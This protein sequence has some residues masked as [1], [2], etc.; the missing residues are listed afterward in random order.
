ML[1]GSTASSNTPPP[2]EEFIIQL[3]SQQRYA[4]VYALLSNQQLTQTSSLYNLALCLH[5]AGSYSEALNQLDSIKL[6]P[7]L[8]SRD[9]YQTDTTYK[10][11]KSKQDLTSDYL[12]GITEAYLKTFPALV[13]DAIIRLKTDC[14]LQLGNYAK[15]IV[16]ATPIVHKGYKDIADALKLAEASKA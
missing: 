2:T 3:L 10:L 6:A 16:I 7:Q 12:Q 13:Q 5:W 9:Q 11:I 15:V 4:E 1:L 14:W 8:N